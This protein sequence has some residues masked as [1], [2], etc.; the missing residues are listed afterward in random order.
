MTH[1]RG[2]VWTER[3]LLMLIVASLA[4]TLN[5]VRTMHRRYSSSPSADH[6]QLPKP[7][8]I[9]VATPAPRATKITS[10]SETSQP[11]AEPTKISPSQPPAPTIEDPTIKLLA[12]L[13]RATTNEIEATRLA[14]R[15][16]SKLETAVK[17]AT[18]DSL[19]WKRREVLVR[20]Q[21]AA[22]TEKAT[23]LEHGDLELE[24]ERDVLAQ[25]RDALKVA[26]TKSGQRSGNSILP[27]K[28]PNGTWRRPIV[29]E[30]TGNVAI[31][32]PGGRTFSMLELS[33]LIHP[34]SS[35]VVLAIAREMMRVQQSA[36]PDGAPAV[37]YLVF[38]VR[39]NGIRPYYESRAR[40]EPLGIAFGYELI[41]Q[42]L[43]VEVPDYDD[44]TTWD[45]SAPL[46]K[47][48]LATSNGRP[49]STWQ[50]TNDSQ[51]S[52]RSRTSGTWPPDDP[53]R[54][55]GSP[56]GGGWPSSRDIGAPAGPGSGFGGGNLAQR[57]PLREG[58]GA[59]G[60]DS[61]PISS[62]RPASELVLGGSSGRDRSP[63]S[64]GRTG[65]DE[66]SPQDFVWP[67]NSR[68]AGAGGAAVPTA[69]SD[70]SPRE[71]AM[72]DATG[73]ISAGAGSLS[74]AAS[75][76]GSVGSESGTR[77]LDPLSPV[78]GGQTG[79]GTGTVGTVIGRRVGGPTGSSTGTPPSGR[80]GLSSGTQGFGSA[81]SSSSLSS[82]SRST[83]GLAA[84]QFGPGGPDALPE[85]EPAQD[86]PVPTPAS[87]GP[88]SRPPSSQGVQGGS[89]G[90]GSRPFGTG[91]SAPGASPPPT[92][93]SISGGQT[94]ETGTGLP[95][96]GQ[97]PPSA[98]GSKTVDPSFNA[99]PAG[100][101]AFGGTVPGSG[102]AGS[103]PGGGSVSSD[104]DPSTSGGSGLPP[105]LTD[106]TPSA[107]SGSPPPSYGQS[108]SA[109]PGAERDNGLQ[110]RTGRR[111]TVFRS[112]F[113][114][115]AQ[116]NT[117]GRFD[118]F[119]KRPGKLDRPPGI[120][121]FERVVVE[122]E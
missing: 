44:L 32:Q 109:P 56:A 76:S 70:G 90:L 87:G 12:G 86:G 21:V 38:L 67:G 4:G 106:L 49:R 55:G 73:S 64:A 74:P 45:G 13:T 5:L 53:A 63:G 91:S 51:G 77:P 59:Y 93:D 92:I 113:G 117:V 71:P 84:N 34:R 50:P 22:L 104:R 41:E 79:F 116:L 1:R 89:S 75:G 96:E 102:T 120:D 52:N 2:A 27:Y 58:S 99:Y 7:T 80:G 81:S 57:G 85:L 46:E 15:R 95:D 111:I 6:A 118:D 33:P 20:Q 31:L 94:P 25:E 14:D 47:P 72:G 97:N 17:A 66:T 121:A 65:T 107:A 10:S 42:D 61:S 68:N 48:A 83:P 103:S 30:C 18:A 35:P 100:G 9:P 54:A 115:H 29:V 110:I 60:S 26:L 16:T 28:G 119:T 23:R 69:A 39:P 36:T 40:L 3:L 78:P 11:L 98:S 8:S 114:V 37:P 43:V 108:L 62:G 24:A 122:H 88:M 105:G 19:R 112:D 101:P 82:G